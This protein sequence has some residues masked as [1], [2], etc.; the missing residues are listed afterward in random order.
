MWA[1]GTAAAAAAAACTTSDY[2]PFELVLW[3]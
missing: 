2:W 1:G 3:Q